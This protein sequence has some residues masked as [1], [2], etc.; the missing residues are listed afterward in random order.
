ML[1]DWSHELFVLDCDSICTPAKSILMKEFLVIDQSYV[2]DKT[3]LGVS[4][5]IN[6]ILW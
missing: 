3:T 1:V 2:H 6:H 4:R 5:G